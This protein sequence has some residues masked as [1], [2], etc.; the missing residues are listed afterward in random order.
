MPSTCLP[1]PTLVHS[2]RLP[3]LP[4][5]WRSLAHSPHHHR[6]RTTAPIL[7]SPSLTHPPSYPHSSSSS[8]T[9]RHDRFLPQCCRASNLASPHSFDVSFHACSLSLLLTSSSSLAPGTPKR[10]QQRRPKPT[11]QV[12]LP[13]RTPKRPNKPRA[14][15]HHTA[16]PLR[17]P[18][19]LN[20]KSITKKKIVNSRPDIFF[21]HSPRPSF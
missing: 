13:R 2:K 18:P 17:A 9:T 5:C 21:S 20:S 16:P 7:P 10:Q 6:R 3:C 8:T 1:T 11:G 4:V 12:S 15:L 14:A 19:Q